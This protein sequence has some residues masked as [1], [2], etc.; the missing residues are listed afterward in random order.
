VSGH[1]HALESIAS[2]VII[3]E[4]GLKLVLLSQLRVLGFS[5]IMPISMTTLQLST[6]FLCEQTA[7]FSDPSVMF[8][9]VSS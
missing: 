3:P 4:M 2:R 6:S 9:F 5:L 8:L 7:Y 1:S